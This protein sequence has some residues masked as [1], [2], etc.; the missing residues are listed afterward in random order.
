MTVCPQI[1][2]ISISIQTGATTFCTVGNPPTTA[3]PTQGFGSMPMRSLTADRIGCWQPRGQISDKPE[4]TAES[5]LLKL[6]P[7]GPLERSHAETIVKQSNRKFSSTFRKPGPV[8]NCALGLR[9]ALFI[10]IYRSVILPGIAAS[11]ALGFEILP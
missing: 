5:D 11:M 6:L 2:V 4:E 7:C 9:K 3:H 1:L 10:P 8:K